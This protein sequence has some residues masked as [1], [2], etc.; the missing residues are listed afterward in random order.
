MIQPYNLPIN[1]SHLWDI[2][3]RCDRQGKYYNFNVAS[4]TNVF[5]DNYDDI[6][7]IDDNIIKPL[8]IPHSLL[9]N[10]YDNGPGLNFNVIKPGGFV[11][12]HFSINDTKLNILLNDTTLAPILFIETGEKYYYEH[13]VLLDVGQ[14]HAVDNCESIVEDRVMLQLFLTASYEKCERIINENRNY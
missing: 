7:Y 6:K 8:G 13:P 14:L 11:R 12:P 3:N 5:I 2:Y 1:K 4:T 10:F 9:K